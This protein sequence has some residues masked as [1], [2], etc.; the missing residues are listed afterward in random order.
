M[1]AYVHAVYATDPEVYSG[2]EFSN[3]GAPE[4]HRQEG[5]KPKRRMPAGEAPSM[6]GWTPPT[7]LLK[8]RVWM[9]CG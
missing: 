2:E 3:K 4:C 7:M 6:F 9:L 8:S 1:Y 5:R